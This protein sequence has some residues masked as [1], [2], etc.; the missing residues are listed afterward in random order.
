M[1]IYCRIQS[2]LLPTYQYQISLKKLINDSL[3][4][5]TFQ[6]FMKTF[7]NIRIMHANLCSMAS[8]VQKKNKMTV[9]DKIKRSVFFSMCKSTSDY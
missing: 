7:L 2:Y 6:N 1:A 3:D 8:L 4:H 5:P 9:Q